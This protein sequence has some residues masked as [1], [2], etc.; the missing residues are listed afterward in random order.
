M[1]CHMKEEFLKR[2]AGH[3]SR[4]EKDG[5]ARNSFWLKAALTFNDVGFKPQLITSRDVMVQSVF[6]QAKLDPSYTQFEGKMQ[7][8]N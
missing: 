3:L 5:A 1:I 7:E 4:N 2:D 8:F 6:E